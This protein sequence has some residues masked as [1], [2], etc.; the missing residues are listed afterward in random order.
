MVVVHTCEQ[1]V[2]IA[3][4]LQYLHT[5]LGGPGQ[6]F[7]RHWFSVCNLYLF[8]LFILSVS[9]MP[10]IPGKLHFSS[11]LAH[12]PVGSLSCWLP[13]ALY[14]EENDKGDF[15]KYSPTSASLKNGTKKLSFLSHIKPSHQ[16]LW[17]NLIS[18]PSSSWPNQLSSF[19]T[20]PWAVVLLHQFNCEYLIHIFSFEQLKSGDVSSNP[21]CCCG[22]LGCN[23]N[24]LLLCRRETSWPFFSG[25]YSKK[26]VSLQPGVSQYSNF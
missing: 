12:C 18:I 6:H 19:Y 24:E 5:P 20:S 23:S 4:H 21:R 2:I 10:L 22:F 17:T 11:V 8:L 14:C 13:V 1:T 7:G 3:A 9:R 16:S 25:L 15:C 26:L